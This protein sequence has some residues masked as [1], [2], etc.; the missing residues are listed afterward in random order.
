MSLTYAETGVLSREVTAINTT[1]T[2]GIS[3]DSAPAIA[4]QQVTPIAPVNTLTT[5]EIMHRTAMLAGYTWT[6]VVAR[7]I[8]PVMYGGTTL[9]SDTSYLGQSSPWATYLTGEP[10]TYAEC[11]SSEV[12]LSYGIGERIEATDIRELRSIAKACAKKF[13]GKYFEGKSYTTREEYLMMLLTMFGEKISLPGVFSENGQ[14]QAGASSTDTGFSNV[15]KKSWFAPYLFFARAHQMLSNT[16]EW[17]IAHPITDREAIEMLANYTAYR[18]NYTGSDLTKGM[19]MTDKLKYTITFFSANE[20]TIRVQPVESN[21]TTTSIT[22]PISSSTASRYP[23]CDTDDIVL[24]NRQVWAAC[25]V[26]ASKAGTGVESY[27]SLFQWGRNVPFAS[28]GTITTTTWPITLATANA[29]TNY[30]VIKPNLNTNTY[31]WLSTR[32]DI[33]WWSISDIDTYATATPANQAKMQWPCATWY[34]VPTYKEVRE[35]ESELPWSNWM[36][37]LK[38][39]LSGSR[40]YS[41]A[42]LNKT[43]GSGGNWWLSS[44]NSFLGRSVY[45]FSGYVNKDYNSDRAEGFGVRCLKN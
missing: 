17:Q 21:N 9:G 18:M 19:I 31:D 36:T 44:S 45:W 16:T 10:T 40:D 38:A 35:T 8:T 24:S 1:L 33:L 15:D 20:V 5:W 14:Y 41:N 22:P 25:N 32:D 4:A 37:T 26:G 42:S 23:G 43:Q 13:Y 6:G 28:T 12:Y 7:Y 11:L 2:S 27:G 3:L 34:H 29:T 30:I 39:P